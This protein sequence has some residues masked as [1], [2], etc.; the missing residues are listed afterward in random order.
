MAIYTSLGE[1]PDR[2]SGGLGGKLRDDE[3]LLKGIPYRGEHLLAKYA[4]YYVL[5]DSRFIAYQN[6][7]FGFETVDST[8]TEKISRIES[9]ATGSSG[10]ATTF[11]LYGSGFE[12]EYQ[13]QDREKGGEDG[14][15]FV[16]ALRNQISKTAD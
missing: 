14:Q 8:P 5:T 6:A 7:P 15:K 2:V 10:Y 9:V 4:K 11:T 13:I 3:T 12:E 16:N 1:F